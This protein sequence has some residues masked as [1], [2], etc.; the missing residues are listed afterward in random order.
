VLDREGN[1]VAPFT[2]ENCA[3]LRCDATRQRVTWQGADSLAPVRAVWSEAPLDE[4]ST[5]REVLAFHQEAYTRRVGVPSPEESVADER[6]LAV[7]FGLNGDKEKAKEMYDRAF[8]TCVRLRQEATKQQSGA[9]D[10]G[11]SATETKAL[12]IRIQRLGKSAEAIKDEMSEAFG[13]PKGKV[14]PLPVPRRAAP[15]APAKKK[16][17]FGIFG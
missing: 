6:L 9:W 4:E 2:A 14:V 15:P 10:S 13:P 8:D 17:I 1:V 12:T 7:L 3:P 11:L 5:R 16:K